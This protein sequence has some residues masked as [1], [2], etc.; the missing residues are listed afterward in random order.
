MLER[1]AE[2]EHIGTERIAEQR[3]GGAGGVE[4]M[5]LVV[6]GGCAD[7]LLQAFDRL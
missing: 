6:A 7:R 1:K 2:H 3:G 4:E 5:R